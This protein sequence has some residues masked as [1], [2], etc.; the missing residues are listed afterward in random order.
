MICISYV[1]LIVFLLGADAFAHIL[2]G[3]SVVQVASQH[4]KEGSDC[5]ERIINELKLIM[6]E[7]GYSCIDD[8]KGKLRQPKKVKAR[9]IRSRL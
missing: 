9:K 7:K 4:A 8:F 3:A 6:N 2:C 5:F 1:F